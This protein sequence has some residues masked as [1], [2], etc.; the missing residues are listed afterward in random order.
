MNTTIQ[1]THVIVSE[2]TKTSSRQNPLI[3]F[4]KN[5]ES[6]RFGIIPIL[7]VIIACI[8]G[9]T[10]AYATHSDTF[11]LALVVF[12]TIISLALMLAVAPMKMILRLSAIAVLIDIL[13]FIF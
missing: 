6:N 10:A 13:L 3:E 1:K 4:W 7:L 9:G 8:G 2:N 11:R 5:C 12:P